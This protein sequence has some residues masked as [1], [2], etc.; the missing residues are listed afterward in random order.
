MPDIFSF[1]QNY[2]FLYYLGFVLI[3]LFHSGPKFKLVEIQLIFSQVIKS[4]KIKKKTYLVFIKSFII[5]NL[6]DIKI[7]LLNVN[8]IKFA[9][10]VSCYA[11]INPM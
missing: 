8:K 7:L 2:L 6:L 1:N 3:F 4:M 9:I 5:F 10:M 11:V